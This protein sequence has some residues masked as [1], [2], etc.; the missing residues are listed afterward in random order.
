MKRNVS[1]I[2]NFFQNKKPGINPGIY[3]K[4]PILT[5]INLNGKYTKS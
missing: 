1:N 3:Y 2:Q 4:P 5:K